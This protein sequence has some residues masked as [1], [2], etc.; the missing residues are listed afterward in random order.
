MLYLLCMSI[1]ATAAYY[2]A[3]GIWPCIM[4]A[5]MGCICPCVPRMAALYCGLFLRLIVG[6]LVGIVLAILTMIPTGE[7]SAGISL[8]MLVLAPRLSEAL[9]YLVCGA[10]EVVGAFLG[11]AIAW[12]WQEEGD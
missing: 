11:G 8:I 3:G 6:H 4:V 12:Q 10:C 5:V 7:I 9:P 2:W 1:I